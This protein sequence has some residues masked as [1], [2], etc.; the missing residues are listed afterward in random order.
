MLAGLADAGTDEQSLVMVE[1][2]DAIRANDFDCMF[3]ELQKFI[4]AVPYDLHQDKEAYYHSLIYLLLKVL[5]LTIQAEVHTNRGRVDAV[6][7]SHD[8]V[9]IFEFKYGKNAAKALAQIKEWDTWFNNPLNLSSFQRFYK[10]P[11]LDNHQFQIYYLLIYGRREEYKN[12]SVLSLQRSSYESDKLK[13]MSYDRLSPNNLISQDWCVKINNK[14]YYAITMP[15]T[16][17]FT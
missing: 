6:I 14:G 5:G 16:F 12:N 10:I 17:K 13:I 9:M 7:I 11:L 1:L 3:G 2:I 8:K 4:A 15:P